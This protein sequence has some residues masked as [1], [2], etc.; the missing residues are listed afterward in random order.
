VAYTYNTSGTLATFTD[1]NGDVTQYQYD[2]QN[3]MISKTDPRGVVVFQNAFDANG[4]VSQQVQ[5]DG[6]VVQ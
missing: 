1:A 2:S 6:G 5:A 4:R 3:R